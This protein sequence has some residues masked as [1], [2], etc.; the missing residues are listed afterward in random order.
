MVFLVC[1][2]Q[3]RKESSDDINKDQRAKRVLHTF[4]SALKKY[5]CFSLSSNLFLYHDY[6]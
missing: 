6:A 4:L 1:L 3:V 5:L 2:Q